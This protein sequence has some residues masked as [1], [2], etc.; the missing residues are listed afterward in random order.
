MQGFIVF[1]HIAE[2]PQAMAAMRQCIESGQLRDAENIV[3]GF[4]QMPS[5]LIRVFEGKNL[6]K[7]LVRVVDE[8][9][10]YGRISPL[11]QP[12]IGPD[13][14]DRY[15]DQSLFIVDTTRAMIQPDKKHSP[16]PLAIQPFK[17]HVVVISRHSFLLL[18]IGTSLCRP[19]MKILAI[20]GDQSRGTHLPILIY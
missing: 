19:K 18:S 7:Q 20:P 16:P 11:P 2:Y 1:D 4:E 14:V 6:G 5:A 10:I 15:T 8:G 9:A 17:P 12:A 3:D 13:P